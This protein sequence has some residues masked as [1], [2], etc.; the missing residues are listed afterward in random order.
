MAYGLSLLGTAARV[1][2]RT[3][4]TS[5][6]V[7]VPISTAGSDALHLFRSRPSQF[8]L[9]EIYASI[10][11]QDETCYPRARLILWY[12][13]SKVSGNIRVSP[14]TEMKFESA[15]QRGSTCM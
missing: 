12:V 9:G 5:L 1:G 8:I 6:P 10:L 11:A 13:V 7:L 4:C 15:T 14:I 2:A 3:F